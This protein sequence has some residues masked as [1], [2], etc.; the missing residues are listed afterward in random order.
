LGSTFF[1]LTPKYRLQ[2]QEQIFDLIYYGKGF[3]YTEAYNMPVYLRHFFI[4]K[5]NELHKKRQKAEEKASKK[6][7]SSAKAKAPQ[8]RRPKLR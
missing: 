5:I 1:G 7:R 2:V 6:A 8:F 4:R 3:S